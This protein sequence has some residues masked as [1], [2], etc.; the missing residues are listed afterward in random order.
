MSYT[1]I[2]RG[3]EA[4]TATTQLTRTA[5]T[6]AV[7]L[8]SNYRADRENSRVQTYILLTAEI[9]KE[10]GLR[11]GQRVSVLQGTGKDAGKFRIVANAEGTYKLGRTTGGTYSLRIRTHYVLRNERSTTPATVTSYGKGVVTISI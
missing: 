3:Y 4:P 6:D 8:R 1:S 10:A 11:A 5:L 2:V 7:A 9:A